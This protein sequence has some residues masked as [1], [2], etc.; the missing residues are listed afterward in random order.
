MACLDVNRAGVSLEDIMKEIDDKDVEFVRFEFGDLHGIARSKIVPARHFRDKA[1][2]G[3]GIP[4][5]HMGL[6]S[7]G[8]P[9]PDAMYISDGKYSD[10]LWLPDLSTFRLLPWCDNTARVII[11]PVLDGKPVGLFP[12]TL[13]RNQVKRL[14]NMGL[15]LLTAHEHEFYVVNRQTGQPLT[16]DFNLRATVR[17]Y[18][19]PLLISSL[20]RALPAV[21]VDS[22]MI[23]TEKSPGQV[24][25]TY[26]P[27]FGIEAGDVAHTYKTTIKE[28]A[29]QRG[30]VASFMSKPWPELN[31]SS[32]HICHS[33]WDANRQ[34]PL[35]YDANHPTGISKTGRHWIAGLLAHAP[36]LSVIMAPTVNCLKRFQANSFAPY[37][38]TWGIDNRTCAI[39]AKVCGPDTYLENRMGASGSNPYLT[40]AATIA[41]GIDGIQR[42]LVPPEPVVNNAYLDGN[43]P[44]DTAILP[45]TMDAALEA[46]AQDDV[47]RAAL[48]EEFVREFTVLKMH[49]M[50]EYSK[51]H[52]KQ[53]PKWEYKMYF[54][55]I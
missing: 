46:L 22:E 55:Y 47:M 52:L 40:I 10:A 35:L 49:E 31:G 33:L 11:E 24:E 12:R 39:R 34:T 29:M 14:Y 21:G 15:S 16:Q 27:R 7:K 42:E 1:T 20:M 51:A 25:I 4:I 53:D 48:G 18:T 5:A 23:D 6:D 30:Y 38:A 43:V 54:E 26:K 37:N 50:K 44:G 41:A 32:A 19:D 8:I 2:R 45:S 36:A 3:I 17:N 9:V 13:A 28:V